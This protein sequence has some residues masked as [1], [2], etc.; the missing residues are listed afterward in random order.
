MFGVELSDAFVDIT[1]NSSPGGSVGVLLRLHI[2]VP[3]AEILFF[4]HNS[5]A[6]LGCI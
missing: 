5:Q 3:K 2:F 4:L 6:F 1:L